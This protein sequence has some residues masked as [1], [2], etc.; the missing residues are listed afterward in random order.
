LCPLALLQVASQVQL[1]Y[2]PVQ[3]TLPQVVRLLLQLEH[4]LTHLEQAVMLN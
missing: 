1:S 4:Q 3:E 2:L